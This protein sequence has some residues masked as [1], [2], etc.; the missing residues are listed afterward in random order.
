MRMNQFLGSSALTLLKSP[1]EVLF[2]TTKH[3]VADALTGGPA[4]NIFPFTFQL[5]DLPENGAILIMFAEYRIT[6]VTVSLAPMFRAN[7]I[8]AEATIGPIP[9]ILIVFSPEQTALATKAEFERYQNLVINDD[10]THTNVRFTPVVAQ[11]VYNTALSNGLTIG[12]PGT[13]IPTNQPTVPHYGLHVLIEGSGLFGAQ[14][15]SWNRTVTY[16]LEF[17]VSR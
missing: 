4:D 1:K 16:N 8:V 2:R 9:R 6:S 14:Y 3:L 15:Q 11:T 13:W 17:R 10:S 5:S 12:P 7:T